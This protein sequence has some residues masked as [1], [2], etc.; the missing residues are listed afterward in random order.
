MVIKLHPPQPNYPSLARNNIRSRAW[1]A[2]IE[3]GCCFSIEKAWAV[4]RSGT[5]MDLSPTP[6]GMQ[7]AAPT[8]TPALLERITTRSAGAGAKQRNNQELTVIYNLVNEPWPKYTLMAVAD[9][10]LKPHEWTSARLQTAVLYM[11]SATQRYELARKGNVNGVE[12]YQ[13]SRCKKLLTEA[14]MEKVGIPLPAKEKEVLYDSLEWEKLAWGANGVSI[15]GK[16]FY[17]V[18][19]RFMETKS[20]GEN[21]G[22]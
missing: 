6:E 10:G 5:T 17:L 22:K 11:E 2:P 14:M 18:R 12:L 21:G 15:K 8:F 19:V 13:F 9:R 16:D 1:G 7:P 4:T 3:D 20:G